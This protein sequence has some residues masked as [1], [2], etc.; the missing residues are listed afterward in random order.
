MNKY[1]IYFFVAIF[2][3]AHLGISQFVHTI[4]SM[5]QSDK[6]FKNIFGRPPTYNDAQSYNLDFPNSIQ[7]KSSSEFKEVVKTF[8]SKHGEDAFKRLLIV[9][10]NSLGNLM[11]A[12][13]S[14]INLLEVEEIIKPTIPTQNAYILSCLSNM[15]L[16]KPNSYVRGINSKISYSNA[17]HIATN[18]D[19]NTR[20]CALHFSPAIA[21]DNA[22]HGAVNSAEVSQ[23][24]SLAIAAGTVAGVIYILTKEDNNENDLIVKDGVMSD[25]LTSGTSFR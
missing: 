10:H 1:I 24:F 4:I 20:C 15:Y 7:V 14:E 16:N 21:I 19:N 2:F 18:I 3:Q 5:P 8:K 23:L 9:G 11:F 6:E 22:I 17:Y 25:S 12:D 13:S